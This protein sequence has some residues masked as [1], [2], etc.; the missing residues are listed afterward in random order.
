MY[1]HYKFLLHFSKDKPDAETQNIN[2][3]EKTFASLFS[4]AAHTKMQ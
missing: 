1:K 4:L 3:K 2:V